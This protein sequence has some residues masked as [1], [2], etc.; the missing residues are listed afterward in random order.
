MRRVHAYVRT[1]SLASKERPAGLVRKT[2]PKPRLWIRGFGGPAC[3]TAGPRTFVICLV[4]S[5]GGRGNV[6]VGELS[7]SP[8]KLRDQHFLPFHSTF[9]MVCVTDVARSSCSTCNEWHGRFQ[10]WLVDK[11]LHAKAR[12]LCVG[13]QARST[14]LRMD[15]VRVFVPVIDAHPHLSLLACGA[16]IGVE[17]TA[18]LSKRAQSCQDT[19]AY[20]GRVHPLWRRENLDMG[21]FH[22]H[23]LELFQ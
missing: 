22:R 13:E 11:F 18:H 10:A 15:D 8:S 16:F 7:G 12:N 19:A 2:A 9:V 23:A 3:S 5:V 1:T 4:T 17:S 14:E 6:P 21:I 20:P